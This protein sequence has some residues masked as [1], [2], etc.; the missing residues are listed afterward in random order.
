[1]LFLLQMKGLQILLYMRIQVCPQ[2]EQVLFLVQSSV[3]VHAM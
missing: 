1:M 3:A 2:D